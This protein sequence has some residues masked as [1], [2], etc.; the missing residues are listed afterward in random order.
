GTGSNK[1][2]PAQTGSN[3]TK[4]AQTSFEGLKPESKGF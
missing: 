4:T 3:R 1:T 2:R